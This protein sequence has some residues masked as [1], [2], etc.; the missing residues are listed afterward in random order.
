VQVVQVQPH[1]L[2]A[3]QQPELAA[4][5]VVFTIAITRKTPA[6]LQAQAVEA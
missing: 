1:L 3:L 6:A 2:T 5:A 4:V